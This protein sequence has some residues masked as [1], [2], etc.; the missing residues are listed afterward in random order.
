MPAI[1]AI[2]LQ[3]L[4]KTSRAQYNL[5][6]VRAEE[7]AKARWAG[8]Q[9]GHGPPLTA[10]ILQICEHGIPEKSFDKLKH[11]KTTDIRICT[12]VSGGVLQKIQ[13]G[14]CIGRPLGR[15]NID[16]HT[17][18]TNPSTPRD[19][20]VSWRSLIR[21]RRGSRGRGAICHPA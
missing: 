19:S 14:A 10:G 15:A 9:E 5:C 8:D 12:K 2:W 7:V 13:F 21:P 4:E 18:L 11:G 1:L 3:M 6:H 20:P 17:C 16:L